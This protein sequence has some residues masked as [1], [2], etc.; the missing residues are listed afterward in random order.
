MNKKLF[1]FS[2]LIFSTNLF[3]IFPKYAN[4]SERFKA[5]YEFYNKKKDEHGVNARVLSI[6][7]ENPI[8]YAS[9]QD[10]IRKIDDNQSFIVYFGYPLCPWCRANVES[11]ILAACDNKIEQ[12]YYVDVSD[13]RDTYILKRGNK[14]VKEK[15]ADNDYYQLLNRLQN[16][17]DDYILQDADGNNINVN[18]K[19]IYAP[20][21]IMVRDGNA[22]SIAADSEKITDPYM[23]LNHEALND[24]Y[25]IYNN[26]F[27]EFMLS[28]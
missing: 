1:A 15:S 3:I 6:N 5:E 19:R 4:D 13:V 24:L 12:I 16:V 17:L 26:M 25:E 7:A 14:L 22:M 20:N 2:F 11:M 28:N 10:I 23:V 8:V 21:V 27:K 9:I 18:E